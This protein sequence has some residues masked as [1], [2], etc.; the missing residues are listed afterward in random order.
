M[1]DNRNPSGKKLYTAISRLKTADE[2]AAFM[3]DLCSIKEIQDMVHRFETAIALDSGKN[4][5]SIASEFGVS[6]ATIS[7]VN[8]SLEY[9][10][11]GYRNAI[12]KLKENS[13]NADK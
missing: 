7:R 9:G 1:K 2:V 10:T 13:E 11:G 6:T 4:Y 12:E 5:I 3:E 8:R